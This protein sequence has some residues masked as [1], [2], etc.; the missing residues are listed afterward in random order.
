MNILDFPGEKI[1]QSC[2]AVCVEIYEFVQLA[3]YIVAVFYTYS[4]CIR[5]VFPDIV[6]SRRKIYSLN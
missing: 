5:P 2:S 4:M 3:V 6:L 1:L